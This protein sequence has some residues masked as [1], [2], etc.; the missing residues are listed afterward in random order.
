MWTVLDSGVRSAA[1]NMAL[2]D[3][4]LDA[5]ADES[6]S[7]L[8]LYDWQGEAATFGYF[9]D[10]FTFLREEVVRQ[11]GVDLAKRPTG[12]G[13]IFHS[14]DLAFSV[15][16][17]ASAPHFSTNPLENY[18]Y[19]NQRVIIAIQRLKG[20]KGELLPIEPVAMDS[21]SRHFCMAK[22]TKYDV[23]IGGKKVGGAA[24]RKTRFG[25]LHQGSI[26]LR[27]LCEERYREMLKGEEVFEN[28]RKHTY[29]LL[30]EKASDKEYIEARRELKQLLTEVFS[31]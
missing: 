31:E 22:P 20:I 29:T 28:M 9:I 14:T 8:H 6:D 1:E 23:M 12:G 25:F 18:V 13:V 21:H 19:V 27:P 24:Q 10:P 30:G 26:S 16:V 4:L 17:P 15:L 2:D 11:A 7:L 3:A 5:C